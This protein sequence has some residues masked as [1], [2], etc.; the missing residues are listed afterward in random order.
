MAF[1]FLIDRFWFGDHLTRE[2]LHADLVLA[3]FVQVVPESDVYCLMVDGVMT[4]SG[5]I[6]ETLDV[7]GISE[8][9]K[10]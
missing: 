3:H 5:Q 10:R 4:G 1:R 8:L 9:P 2:L 7:R 6:V